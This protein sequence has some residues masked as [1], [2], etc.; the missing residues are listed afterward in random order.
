MLGESDSVSELWFPVEGSGLFLSS[1]TRTVS[2]SALSSGTELVNTLELISVSKMVLITSAYLD[3]YT[4]S[5]NRAH[6]SR[7]THSSHCLRTRSAPSR[8][9]GVSGRM[10]PAK[11]SSCLVI[12]VGNRTQHSFVS[13]MWFPSVAFHS[14]CILHLKR[15]RKTIQEYKGKWYWLLSLRYGTWI[16]SWFDC[17]L[18][19]TFLRSQ[20][21]SCFLSKKGEIIVFWYLSQYRHTYWTPHFKIQWVHKG[22]FL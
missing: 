18:E 3:Q 12:A 4:C 14:L 2:W 16:V 7:I 9:P 21:K 22:A 13:S 10:S 8:V 6:V 19:A 20:S 15:K 5:Q 1:C 11:S 17:C